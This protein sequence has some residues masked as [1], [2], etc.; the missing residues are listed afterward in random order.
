MPIDPQEQYW[1]S[2]SD[3]E[4]ILDALDE[5][6]K[7]YYDDLRATGLLTMYERA[8]RSY[9]GG[10]VTQFGLGESIFETSKLS[11]GGKQGEK[12][13]LKANHSRNLLKHLHQL[14]TAQKPDVQGRAANSDSKSQSQTILASGLL[15]YYWREK[16]LGHTIKDAAEIC[17]A[18]YAEAFVYAPWNESAGNEVENL[19]GQVIYEGEQEFKVLSPLNVIRDPALKDYNNTNWIIVKLERNKWDLFAENSAYIEDL[20]MVLSTTNNDDVDR[21]PSFSLRGG[22]DPVNDDIVYEYILFHKKSKVLPQGRMI[23][24]VP[25][26]KLFDGPLPYR[27]IPVRRLCAERLY[28]TGYGYTVAWDLLSLQD[29]IDTLHTTLMS[30]N[31]TFGIQSIWSP[32]EGLQVSTIGQGMQLFKSDVEPKAIQLT[33]SAP[34]TYNYLGILEHTQ[35]LLSGISSTVRGNP[36]ANLKSG[37]ALALVVSQSMQFASGLEEAINRMVEELGLDII[38]NLKDFGSKSP[39]V[40]NI[41]GKSKRTLAKTFSPDEDLSEINRVIV[42][43]VNPLSKTIAGRAEMANNLLQ[44]GII[45]TAED[46][47]QWITTG[48]GD[49]TQEGS[50][51]ELISIQAENEELK[52][53]RPVQAVLVENHPLHIQHHKAV[54]SDPESKKDP[55]LIIATLNHIQEHLDLWAQMPPALLAVL[56]MQPPPLPAVTTPPTAN[57]PAIQE[58]AQTDMP[59]MPS[60]PPGTPVE[61]QAQYDKMTATTP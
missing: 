2:S 43:Q 33:K 56:G 51:L 34:E 12:T 15:D 60:L 19:T 53:G 32:D 13:R 52:E 41:I 54:I 6:I 5:K 50:Q 35:E 59:N 30:N 27:G 36:E 18:I 31:K 42:E 61:A 16:N 17:L 47:I 38:N 49:S 7:N 11:R 57:P 22:N 28:E 24:F 3:T 55:A 58:A 10:R 29:G 44:Q 37:N 9:Y 39:R 21:N 14:T 25:G 26:V 46:Y 4:E 45:K 40:A 23:R 20:K 48:Q 8:Y 1:A